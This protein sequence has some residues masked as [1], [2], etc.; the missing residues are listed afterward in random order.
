LF[1]DVAQ[2][3]GDGL[4]MSADSHEALAELIVST[5]EESRSGRRARS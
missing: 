5:I 3:G 1:A 4:H 2:A